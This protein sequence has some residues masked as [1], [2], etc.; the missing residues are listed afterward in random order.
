M[1]QLTSLVL[2]DRATTPIS[3]TFEPR[4]ITGNVG[5]VVASNGVPLG[6]KTFTVSLNRTSNGRYKAVLK[7][8]FPVVQ[9]Q[10]LNGITSP[11]VVRTAYA[12]LTFSFDASSTEQ[13]R[14]DIVGMVQ[15]SLDANKALTNDVLVKLQGVY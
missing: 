15:S 2:K 7:G 1:P 11:V 14:N 9:D 3:H 10:V 5:A 4:D 12:E 6:D 8:V 13:E